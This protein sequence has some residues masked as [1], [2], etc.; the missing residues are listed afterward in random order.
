[1][2]PQVDPAL[3]ITSDAAPT[4]SLT[5]N[6]GALAQLEFEF[7]T[8]ATLEER[9]VDPVQ[10]PPLLAVFDQSVEMP[11]RLARTV[12]RHAP[13]TQ[14]LFLVT[15][16]RLD[17]FRS[18]L[19]GTPMIGTNWTVVDADKAELEAA[20]ATAVRSSR[21][22]RQLRTNLDAINLRLAGPRPPA[23]SSEYRK[24]VISDK[25]LA[26]ILEHAQ[27][28]IVSLDLQGRI[29]SWNRG[30]TRLFGYSL[31][32]ALDLRVADLAAADSRRQ[33]GGWFDQVVDGEPVDQGEISCRR[34]DGNSFTAEVTI[35]PVR[36]HNGETI[37]A[38]LIAR[39]VTRRKET[40]EEL[41]SIQADLESRVAKRTEALRYVNAELE[42][43]TYSAS[44]DLRAPLRGIDGF[45]LALLEDYGEVL[46]DSAVRY[47]ERIRSGAN[48]MGEIIDALLMLSRISTV[49]L[50]LGRVDIGGISSEIVR[51][52]QEA[53]PER[54]VELVVQPDLV[55]RADP[56]LMRIALQN[57]LGNAWKFTRERDVAVI[58]VGRTG[59]GDDSAFFVRDNGAGFNMAYAEKLFAPFQRVHQPDRFE[60]SGIG[61]GTVQ[62]VINR[63][64]GKVWGVGRPDEGATFYF[65]LP[66]E[67]TGRKPVEN[68]SA[69]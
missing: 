44:H 7:L 24:L 4:P 27:D 8:P 40:E 12:Y 49:T 57:L 10:G 50:S 66:T 23:D 53:E 29:A 11:L 14:I 3:W 69:R 28:A 39:D 65:Q 43:F 19:Q 56:Q 34:A 33:L 38:S 58:T 45:S 52:L 37:A 48:R 18:E 64:G 13:P 41:R 1:M 6:Q 47:I 60:G 36:D 67:S 55:V 46:D 15:A 62:R 31:Q 21:Q 16:D 54:E 42:A 51:E 22:R 59:E 63:H 5:L 30:A 32:D 17:S 20:I 68:A 25:Y 26:T 2:P 61:L 35:A 9:L